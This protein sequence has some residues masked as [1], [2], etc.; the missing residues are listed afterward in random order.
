MK[1]IEFEKKYVVAKAIVD[2][3][4]RREVNFTEWNIWQCYADDGTRFRK[5]SSNAEWEPPVFFVKENKKSIKLGASFS[6]N[7][8]DAEA[9]S[10]TEF[11]Q[12]WDKSKRRLEKL[13]YEI[14]LTGRR[15]MMVDLF[16]TQDRTSG[17]S[18]RVY[19][20]IA[21]VEAILD[22]NTEV[23]NLDFS[24]PTC[25]QE[26]ILKA[27]DN[28][29]PESKMFKSINM[30]DTPDTIADLERIIGHLNEKSISGFGS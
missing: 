17:D 5:I 20:A 11:K 14:N 23:L 25:Y 7:I 27:V 8:E 29:D 6:I 13:R 28:N 3:I 19:A 22:A 1:Q 18:Y 9:I 2:E 16:L 4:M 10:E 26:Y 12:Q 24:L 30:I 21:E 15:K